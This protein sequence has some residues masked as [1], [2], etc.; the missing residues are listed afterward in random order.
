MK[1]TLKKLTI[2]DDIIFK[3]TN[4]DYNSLE[5]WPKSSGKKIRNEI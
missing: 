2:L 4:E 3:N 1:C 5:S